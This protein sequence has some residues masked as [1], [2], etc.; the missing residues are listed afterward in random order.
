MT[1]AEQNI[2]NLGKMYQEF[3]SEVQDLLQSQNRRLDAHDK[4]FNALTGSLDAI[5]T[6]I[7]GTNARIDGFGTAMGKMLESIEAMQN[8]IST[9]TELSRVIMNS[10][11]TL[12]S[13][14]NTVLS[15][16]ARVN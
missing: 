1:S 6:S 7:Q 5:H 4:S 3:H 8:E 10:T 13:S 12:A 14:M 16:V 15:V 9:L 11:V 2:E